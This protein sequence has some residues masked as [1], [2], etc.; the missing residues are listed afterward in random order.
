MINS[1]QEGVSITVTEG[2]LEDVLQAVANETDIRFQVSNRLVG[3]RIT[4]DVRA[5]D[6]GTGVQQLLK[7][8]S[9]VSLWDADSNMTDVVVMESHKRQEKSSAKPNISNQRKKQNA[10]SSK[11]PSRKSAN[12]RKKKN[13]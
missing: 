8:N 12:S 4:A 1:S 11:A 2:V 6:W 7:G 10:K 3:N 13:T 5:P 9:T